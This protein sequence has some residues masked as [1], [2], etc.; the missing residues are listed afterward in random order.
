MK[1]SDRWSNRIRVHLSMKGGWVWE[2]VTSDGHVV[3]QSD[4]FVDRTL[5]EA[6]ADQQGLPVEG[7]ARRRARSPT[8]LKHSG[9]GSRRR[10]SDG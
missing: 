10:A 6:E 8:T 1:L 5:C 9:A 4:S 7:L 2:L 3:Q